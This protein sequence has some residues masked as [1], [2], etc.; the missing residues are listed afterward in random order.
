MY[1]TINDAYKVLD[2]M[3]RDLGYDEPVEEDYCLL[4]D[5]I[6]L[7]RDVINWYNPDID[8]LRENLRE[9]FLDEESGTDF[10]GIMVIDVGL[11]IVTDFKVNLFS[12]ER[13][14]N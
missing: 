7:S 5:V 3:F 4:E 10:R 13:C 14:L 6:N 1:C 12:E 8:E 11:D 2:S 9:G